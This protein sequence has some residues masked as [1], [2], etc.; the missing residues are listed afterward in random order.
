MLGP[1]GHG[2]QRDVFPGGLT[3]NSYAG[4]ETIESRHTDIEE[5]GIGTEALDHFNGACAIGRG[6]DFVT[7]LAQEYGIHFAGPRTVVDDQYAPALTGDFRS[8]SEACAVT[9][10]R[11]GESIGSD[12]INSLPL[13]MPGLRA[14]TLPP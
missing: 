14:S 1:A 10:L 5:H 4:L 9:E 2:Y 11:D 13:P 8:F 6:L 7:P 12:T 3:A